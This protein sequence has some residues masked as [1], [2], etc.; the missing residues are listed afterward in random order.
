MTEGVKV[1]TIKYDI[2]DVDIDD[3]IS[4]GGYEGETPKP[5]VY[6]ARIQRVEPGYSKD[7]D[8]NEDKD[9]PRLAVLMF[10]EANGKGEETEFKGAP[11]Y[12]YVSFSKAAEWKLAQFLVAIGEVKP[13]AKKMK[14]KGTID[15]DKIK[16]TDIKIR[17]KIEK[18]EGFEPRARVADMWPWDG[19]A[20]GSDDD[21]DDLADDLEDD[22][23]MDEEIPSEEE[24][25]AMKVAD[26]KE[27]A[28]EHDID[29]SGQKKAGAIDTIVEA[30][31][32]DEDEEDDLEED[33]DE[34]D[35]DD[36]E[37]LEDD[38]PEYTAEDIDDMGKADVVALAKEQGVT[39]KGMK[40]SEAKEALKES[41]GLLGDDDE[42]DD[43]V[44]F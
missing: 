35:L 23:E 1:A 30:L 42:D 16:G 33:D 20:A 5:G 4:D 12:D 39:L 9:R 11:L 37:D 38:E 25:R 19:P 8:G 36:D 34:L 2:S 22:D 3:A 32:G 21:A 41:L 43:D 28:E 10:I 13:G 40:M 44:P 29:I 27:L 15:P 18:Q 14:T 17:V 6:R 31:H 24:I 26:L 7:K